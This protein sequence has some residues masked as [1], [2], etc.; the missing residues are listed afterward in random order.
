MRSLLGLLSRAF[1]RGGRPTI[2]LYRTSVLHRVCSTVV[3][4][5]SALGRFARQQCHRIQDVQNATPSRAA[6]VV[7]DMLILEEVGVVCQ[8]S[9]GSCLGPSCTALLS[10]LSVPR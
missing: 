5:G 7:F 1:V 3:L 6:S 2:E 4:Y 9:A 10:T 8:P